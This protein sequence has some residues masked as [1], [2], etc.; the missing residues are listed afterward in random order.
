M[1]IQRFFYQLIFCLMAGCAA[2]SYIQNQSK[3]FKYNI[4]T[5]TL[6]SQTSVFIALDDKDDTGGE[7]RI[8]EINGT[9]LSCH[10]WSCPIWLRTMPG[11]YQVKIEYRSIEGSY[12]KSAI[13][14]VTLKMKTQHVYVARYD[15][16][17]DYLIVYIDDLD[18]N[19]DYGIILG[20]DKQ[21]FPVTF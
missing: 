8:V 14:D 19:P 15:K 5:E 17:E 18:K 2:S 20:P 3:P 9:R 21:Y 11:S 6:N 13:L 1:Q 4:G 12:S 10:F 16:T 7:T